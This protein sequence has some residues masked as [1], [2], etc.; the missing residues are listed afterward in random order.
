MSAKNNDNEITEHDAAG[1]VIA[2]AQ[3]AYKKMPGR[4]MIKQ[5]LV[6]GKKSIQITLV[7]FMVAN[8]AVLDLVANGG[9]PEVEDGGK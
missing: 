2:S 5:G 4:V 9:K 1:L 3:E 6:G 7:D 8:G